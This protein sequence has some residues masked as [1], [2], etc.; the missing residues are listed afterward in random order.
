MWVQGK[1]KQIPMKDSK[2]NNIVRQETYENRKY[3][4][5]IKTVNFMNVE[6]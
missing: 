3:V 1:I 5:E 2:T 6:K 4:K